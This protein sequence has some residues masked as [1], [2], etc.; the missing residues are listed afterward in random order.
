ML[1]L[2]T[3]A[4]TSKV[5]VE[6]GLKSVGAY[7]NNMSTF[8]ANFKQATPGQLDVHQGTFYLKQPRQFLWQYESPGQQ[9]LVS[10][11]GRLFFHDPESDQITQLPLNNPLMRLLTKRPI[12]I[13]NKE[14]RI[15]GYASTSDH[16]EVVLAPRDESDDVGG[17]S[18]VVLSFNRHPLSLAQLVTADALGNETYTFFTNV[19]EGQELS[20]SLFKIELPNYDV[21]ED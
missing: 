1:V 9:K 14:F 15:A 17:L 21:F 4:E 13:P 8:K 6:I 7:L 16:I 10:D 20:A 2:P 12:Q 5:P 3:Q 19:E 11:G 18:R